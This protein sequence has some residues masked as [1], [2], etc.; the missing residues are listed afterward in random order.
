MDRRAFLTRSAGFAGMVLTGLAI[1]PAKAYSRPSNLKIT[2]IRGCTVASNYDYPI[3]K[4]YTNQDVYGLGEVRDMGYLGQALILKP[5][6]VGKDPLDI[7]GI[8]ETLR[9]Y[10]G[11]G[12]FGG[13]FSAVD[14]ALFDIAGKALGVPAYKILGEKVRDKIPGYGDTNANMDLKV[15][16]RRTK[17]RVE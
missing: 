16:A 11:N 3:I 5:Y 12:R 13:G 9:P 8:M 7:E 17:I 14:M 10:T 4:I 15:F 1:D 6:L 2:D